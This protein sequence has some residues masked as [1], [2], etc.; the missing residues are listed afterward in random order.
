[1]AAPSAVAAAAGPLSYSSVR[2]YLECPL[3]WKY[4]Y[5]DRL[6]EAPR[7]YFSF[8][9][10]IH[11]VLEAAVRPL[12]VPMARRTPSGRAQRTL[13][14]YHPGSVTLPVIEAGR[15]PDAETVLEMYRRAW[16]S[17]GYGSPEEEAR[18]RA[19]GAEILLAYWKEVAEDPPRPVAVEEHLEATWDGIRVHGYVDRVD[20]L[21]S[22]GLEVVDYK[23]TRELSATDARESDQLTLYQVLVGENFAAP[24]ERLT[25]YHLRSL[26]P[27]RSDARAQGA[28]DD[29]HGRVTRVRDGIRAEE[30]PPTPGRQCSR[31]DFRAICPEFK[32]V[33]EPERERLSGLV[34]RFWDLR[35]R[36]QTLNSELA[37]TAEELHRAAEKLG[38]HRIPG[39]RTIAV[40]RREETW[41]FDHVEV[42]RILG[43]H[44]SAVGVDRKDPEAVRR[45]AQRSD[46]PAEARAAISAAGSRRTRWYWELER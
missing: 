29:L 22:G 31:C 25:L 23:T 41:R 6:P 5:I 38:I 33:P 7:G 8:G 11:S 9:R 36:E 13:E 34:D 20:R 19:L 3:R 18:Y 45:L 10:T 35:D 42:D 32:E 2:A 43:A 26:T 28:L 46:L 37:A 27:L 14:D 24:V 39:S 12:V 21:D 15:V 30:F 40:R 16:V 17:D 1:M 4:L 44:P